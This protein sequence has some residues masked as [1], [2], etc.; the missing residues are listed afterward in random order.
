M[1]PKVISV[2]SRTSAKSRRDV[3]YLFDWRVVSQAI[4]LGAVCTIF[5]QIC[6]TALS[7]KVRVSPA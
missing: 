1:I 2:G 7:G 5:A 3:R 4:L 6:N